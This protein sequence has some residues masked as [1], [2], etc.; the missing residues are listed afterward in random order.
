MC[1]DALVTTFDGVPIEIIKEFKT[2]MGFTFSFGSH[3]ITNMESVLI[4][5]ITILLIYGLSV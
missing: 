1:E 2:M 3:I 4:A 5:L